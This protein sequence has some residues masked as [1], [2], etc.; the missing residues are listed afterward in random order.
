MAKTWVLDTETKGTGAQMVPL[1][2][3]EGGSAGKSRLN[4]AGPTRRAPAADAPPPRPPASF[5][6][7]DVRSGRVLIEGAGIR[8]TVALLEGV[9]RVVDVTIHVWDPDA[10]EWRQLSHGA[11]RKVWALRDRRPRPTAAPAGTTRADADG[12]LAEPDG[13]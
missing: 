1:E 11:R 6:V 12:D 2:K 9:R 3:V 4:R 8:E 5:K 13:G 7:V 10:A